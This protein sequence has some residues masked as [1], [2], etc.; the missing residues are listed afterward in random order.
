[1]GPETTR[2]SDHLLIILA[3]SVLIG[4]E[5]TKGT[6]VIEKSLVKNENNFN[7]LNNSPRSS[8]M[9]LERK[10]NSFPGFV[11]KVIIKTGDQ[12]CLGNIYSFTL[13][14][15]MAKGLIFQHFFCCS[16]HTPAAQLPPSTGISSPNS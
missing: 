16:N 14:I 7:Q 6:S 10:Y 11:L 3:M 4:T 5:V 8:R 2:S 15:Y 9:F 1:M 13:S 12:L